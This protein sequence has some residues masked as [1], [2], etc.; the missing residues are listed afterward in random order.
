MTASDVDS[1]VGGTPASALRPPAGADP[2]RMPRLGRREWDKVV[3][4]QVAGFLTSSGPYVTVHVLT[5][6]T[7]RRQ[8]L[9]EVLVELR[10]A[11][12]VRAVDL[13]SRPASGA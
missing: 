5:D 4:V 2:S 8:F 9:E 7:Y 11:F 1:L 6:G 12:A 13:A 3:L 10:Q